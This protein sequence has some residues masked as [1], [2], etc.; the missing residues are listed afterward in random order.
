VVAVV[1]SAAMLQPWRSDSTPAKQETVA[2]VPAVPAKG[3]SVEPAQGDQ[4]QRT[5]A[6]PVRER[7]ARNQPAAARVDE[8]A[9]PTRAETAAY[10]DAT[11]ART[12]AAYEA[13][14]RAYSGSTYAADIRRRLGTC[15]VTPASVRPAETRTLTV[16]A[17]AL[18]ARNDNSLYRS[19]MSNADRELLSQCRLAGGSLSDPGSDGY[20]CTPIQDPTLLTEASRAYLRRES[21]RSLDI[22]P[23]GTLRSVSHIFAES[24]WREGYMA[25]RCMAGCGI[26][27]ATTPQTETCE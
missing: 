23:D 2:D 27:S 4:R 17:R 26:P 22:P 8:I 19:A 20:Y 25:Y 16:I 9:S 7:E 15:Q 14:L 21:P 12:R 11:Q 18:G 13:F 1:V 5:V 3:A 6:E 10:T 24:M